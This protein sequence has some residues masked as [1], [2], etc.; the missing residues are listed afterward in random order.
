MKKSAGVLFIVLVVLSMQS[1]SFA[2]NKAVV[3][4]LDT[5]TSTASSSVTTVFF[6]G[7]NS[8]GTFATQVRY[9]GIAGQGAGSSADGH[10]FPVTRN[11]TVS[12]FTLNVTANTLA[13]GETM[14]I[15]L[16]KNGAPTAISQIFDPTTATGVHTVSGTVD[17]A[18][19]DTFSI[20]AEASLNATGAVQFGGAFD[21]TY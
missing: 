9:A 19:G 2:A 7:F 17:Y 5:A 1:L 14:M 8:T 12:N 20:A 11:A 6:Y 21:L 4:P 18:L 10:F 3:V 13:P 16:Q 15:T